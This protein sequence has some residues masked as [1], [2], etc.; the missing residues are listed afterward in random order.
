MYINIYI[1][2]WQAL[3]TTKGG[4]VNPTWERKE[5]RREEKR[6]RKRGQEEQEKGKVR[7]R[8]KGEE[9]DQRHIQAVGHGKGMMGIK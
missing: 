9:K 3:T 6:K 1:Y 5:E 4:R 8:Q 7:E 2:I